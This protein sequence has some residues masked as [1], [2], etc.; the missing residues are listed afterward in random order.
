M[1][2]RLKK[3][4]RRVLERLGD[5]G[6]AL[7][8]PIER[9]FS[10]VTK[11]FLKAT[12]QIDRVESL[13]LQLFRALFWPFRL[14]GR[15]LQAILPK[16]LVRSAARVVSTLRKILGR[17][18][19]GLLRLAEKLNLDRA[20][21]KLVWL[22]QPLWRPVAA[23]C[24]FAQ[25]WLNTRKYRRA[26]KTLPAILLATLVFGVGAW[27]AVFGKSHTTGNYKEAVREMLEEHDYDRAQLFERKL[28]QLGVDTQLTEY[29]TALALAQEEKLE[30]A[31]ARMQL[32]APVDEPG[33]PA[34]HHWITQR[35]MGGQLVRE[36]LVSSP[37]EARSLAKR[38]LDHL[39]TLG[40]TG[41]DQQLLRALW[42][43]Q[44]NQLEEAAAALEPLV[45]ILPSAAIQRMQIDMSLQRP[46][47]ARQDARSL[48]TQMTSRS[49]GRTRLTSTDYQWWLAAEQVLGNLEKMRSIL[50]QWRKLEPENETA[51]AALATICRQ[52][53]QQLL[54]T[55][56]PDAQQV[57]DL[58]LEAEELDQSEE[59]LLQLTRILYRKQG[60]KPIYDRVL[61]VLRNSARVPASVLT[62]LGTEAAVA[63][64]FDEARSF[65]AVAVE[66]DDS[67]AVAWN[68]LALVLGEGEADR[69]DEGL[70]AVNRALEIAPKEYRFRETRGQI[71]LRLERW[72]EAIADLE[73]ALN[74]LPELSEIHQSLATAYTALG[75]DEL[76]RVHQGR[77]N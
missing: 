55:P 45:A 64:R 12:Q 22:L 56:L 1:L 62:T 7:V 43:A 53:A 16:R 40:F 67:S 8:R 59:S 38:H 6:A 20:I 46:E 33:Y 32:M 18:G 76:A 66:K 13:F 71:L 49:R 70:A 17:A 9:L 73:Y 25:C 44:G 72:P 39:K 28:A 74:G 31:Y 36:K 10:R 42:L 14:V 23:I 54:R 3:L 41:P 60:R 5:M 27:H 30:E 37:E 4:Y 61:E 21:M 19:M 69:L 75:D 26:L 63:N 2:R 35:L 57:V 68:N 47:Q 77:S 51:K 11:K 52:Q 58:W 34:A 24:V 50:D 29:R 15:M 65:L 48:V